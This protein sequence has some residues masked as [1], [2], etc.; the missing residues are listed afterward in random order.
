[1]KKVNY[2]ERVEIRMSFE[3]KA[4]LRKLSDELKISEGEFIRRLLREALK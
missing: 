3:M 2:G 4:K 1:M